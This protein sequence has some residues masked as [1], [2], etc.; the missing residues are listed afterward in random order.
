MAYAFT[1]HRAR[2]HSTPSQMPSLATRDI[3]TLTAFAWPAALAPSAAR[4]RS[5]VSAVYHVHAADL[6]MNMH[7]QSHARN[8]KR[9]HIC[10]LSSMTYMAKTA[11]EERPSSKSG[12]TTCGGTQPFDFRS[13][14]TGLAR[15]NT[16]VESAQA[17]LETNC[18]SKGHQIDCMT[19]DATAQ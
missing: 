14:T 12:S 13:R 10:D 18:G 17:K 11:K 8:L 6:V 2:T 19:N 5:C 9:K 15:E 16:G 4:A 3:F 1:Q 7:Y